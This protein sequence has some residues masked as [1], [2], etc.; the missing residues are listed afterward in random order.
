MVYGDAH[1]ARDEDLRRWRGQFAD[2]VPLGR[3]PR[4]QEAT[5]I[6]VVHT[7]RLL[8][9]RGLMVIVEDGTGQLEVL[10]SGRASLPGLELGSGLRVRG[11]VGTS[12]EGLPTMRN[13]DWTLVTEP[14]E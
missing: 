9:G 10:W 6:G 7:I 1:A 11:T 14:Y 2:A 4:R 3:L 13:P 8:P 5:C 12:P